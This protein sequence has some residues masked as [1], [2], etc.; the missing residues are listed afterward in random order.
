MIP[1]C[2]KLVPHEEG[3]NFGNI[4][5][6]IREDVERI[7]HKESNSRRISTGKP[8][9]TLNEPLAILTN[10]PLAISN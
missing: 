5:D 2:Q 10:E 4:L 6:W 1:F 3:K 7:R 8:L 9:A